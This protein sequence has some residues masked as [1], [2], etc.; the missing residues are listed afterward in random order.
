MNATFHSQR[1][2]FHPIG[3][4][5]PVCLAI[6]VAFLFSGELRANPGYHARS[7]KIAFSVGSNIPL[8]KVSGTSSN[9]S[10]GG[11]ATVDQNM[12]TVHNLRFE[13]DPKTFKTGIGMRDQHLYEKVFTAADGS[14]PKITLRAEQFQAKLHPET[15][16]WEGNLRAQLTI[17]GVTKSVSFHV[18]GEKKGNGAVVSADGVVDTSDFGVQP[19]SYSGAR[20]NGQ[21]TVTISDLFIEP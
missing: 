1:A 9:V 7:G 17:R 20:V 18:I 3:F 21:V 15:S 8:V 12:A 19:I 10:G 6:A 5:F 14:M 11:E 16:K 4:V 2:L 13:V